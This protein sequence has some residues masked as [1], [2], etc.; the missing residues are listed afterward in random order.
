M[1]LGAEPFVN[2][3][4]S[5]LGRIEAEG[6]ANIRL[7]DGDGRDVMARLPDASLERSTSSSPIRGPSAATTSA[8]SWTP[9]SPPRPPP[10]ARRRARCVFATDWADYAE[11]ALAALLAEPALGWTAE[12]A[13]DWRRPPADHVPTRYEAKR[14]GDCAPIWLDVRAAMHRDEAD[15]GVGAMKFLDQCKIHVR[16]GDGGGGAV[17]FRR[18]KFIEYGGPDGGDGGRGGDVWIEA[19]EGLNTLI[20]Y[21]YRQHFRAATGGHGMGRQRHGADRR[22]CDAE[23]SGRDGGA[24]GGSRDGRRGPRQRRRTACDWRREGTAASATCA[25]RAR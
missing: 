15:V 7:H 10:V 11:Q 6:L 19:V 1:F 3:V 24:G 18:E 14:L 9:G 17:S 4:A 12:R 2:G 8:V 25:S 21:R 22:G 20:D 16:A 23:G 5:L 13:D